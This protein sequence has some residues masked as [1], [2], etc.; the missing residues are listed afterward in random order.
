[1][2]MRWRTCAG[3]ASCSP[4]RLPED[5]QRQPPG[6]GL[7]GAAR[8]R[9]VGLV[10][11]SRPRPASTWTRRR[12][13]TFQRGRQRLHFRIHAATFG[14]NLIAQAI[15]KSHKTVKK[16]GSNVSLSDMQKS[17]AQLLAELADADSRPA[18]RAP[19]PSLPP[20]E[21]RGPRSTT[22]FRPGS[23][24]RSSPST[25]PLHHPMQI[26]HGICLRHGGG[27][28]VGQTSATCSCI[29]RMLLAPVLAVEARARRRLGGGFSGRFRRRREPPRGSSDAAVQTRAAASTSATAAEP[30]PP[31]LLRR[32]RVGAEDLCV[33]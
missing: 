17:Q 4:G 18:R 12:L 21:A 11:P 24:P 5:G 7:T 15:I 20:P 8:R 26:E 3:R 14:T 25:D 28:G 2:L 9:L 23:A 27:L 13:G 16:T 31:A 19:P 10:M 33:Y 1:M 22:L 32:H 29:A 6:F 30:A